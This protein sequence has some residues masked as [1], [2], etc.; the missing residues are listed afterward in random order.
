VSV[1]QPSLGYDIAIVTRTRVTGSVTLSGVPQSASLSFDGPEHRAAEAT[2]A[3]FEVYLVP[4]SY[5]VSGTKQIVPDQYAFISTA[6]APATGLTYALVKATR[7]AGHALFNGAGVAGPM[8]VS[9]ARAEGGRVNVSIDSSGAYTAYLVPGNYTI[10]LTGTNSAAESGVTRFYAY[11]FTGSLTVAPG[12]TDIAFDLVVSRSLDN[13]TVSGIVSFAG[14]GIDATVTFTARGGGAITASASSGSDGSYTVG[15][16]PGAYDVYASRALG[17]AV[18][19]LQIT[20]PHADARTQDI[21]MASGFVVSGVTTDAQGRRTSASITIQSTASLDLTSDGSGLYS[22][23]LPAGVYA[24]T[25]TKTATE[26]GISVSYQATTSVALQSD[27]VVNLALEKIVSRSVIL[28]WDASQRQTIAAG[29]SVTYTV[30]VR[31]TGNVADTWS[32]S[33]RPTD[34]EFSFVPSTVSLNFGTSGT[35]AGVVVTLT[36]PADALVDHGTITLVATS[37]TDGTTQGSVDVQVDILRTRG[38]SLTL[39]PTSGVFDGRF[40]NNTLTLTNSGNAAETVDVEITNP[41][42]VAAN[43]WIARLGLVGGPASDVRLSG[44]TVPANSTTQVRLQSQSSG[45]GSG[46]TVII[47]A[48]AQDS[49]TVSSTGFF[50]LQMP[51]LATGGIAVVGPEIAHEAPL[52]LQVVAAVVAAVAAVGTGLFLTRRRR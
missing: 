15:L 1:A 12:A 17:S 25:A 24:I 48:S 21:P 28:T 8:P 11:A 38:L 47:R 50:T 26:N 7:V 4:G 46:A 31:N 33:G 42:D 32:L 29:S 6:T 36:S 18:S 13:T 16:A 27:T 14:F 5:A 30:V 23:V 41:D 39:D 20:V 10:T 35:S 2:T 43:G 9:F 22:T 51:A 49:M 3:G 37:T 45:G 40:L 44:V 19:F 52:N 34:W